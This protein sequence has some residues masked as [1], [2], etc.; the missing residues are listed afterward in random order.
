M[1]VQNKTYFVDKLKSLYVMSH[2]KINT[3]KLTKREIIHKYKSRKKH[4]A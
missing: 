2:M 1:Y 3:E 4:V